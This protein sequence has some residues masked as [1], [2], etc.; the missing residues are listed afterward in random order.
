MMIQEQLKQR[1]ERKFTRRIVRKMLSELT[2]SFLY[3]RFEDVAEISV[4]FMTFNI[5]VKFIEEKM[6]YQIVD[7]SF[8]SRFIPEEHESMFEELV[9]L[10]R[11]IS[12]GTIR[13]R[14]NNDETKM[15]MIKIITYLE[16]E[17]YTPVLHNQEY[18]LK[19]VSE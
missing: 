1:L 19:N 5:P 2:D 17:G 9:A 6:R 8:V 18:I 13:S 7:H 11:F 12:P 10:Q 14:D 3:K 15:K 4:W 16:A